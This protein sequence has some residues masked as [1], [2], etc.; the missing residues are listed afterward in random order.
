MQSSNHHLTLRELEILHL[1]SKCCKNSE[2]ANTLILSHHTVETHKAN[3][4]K[5]LKLKNTTELIAYAISNK[6]KIKLQLED[7]TAKQNSSQNIDGGGGDIAETA[8]F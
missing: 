1:I 7:I 2:I 4:V 6:E 5:K 3:L 8:I